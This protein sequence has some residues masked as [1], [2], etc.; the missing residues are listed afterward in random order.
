MP[1]STVYRK[2][3]T[4]RKPGHR[5]RCAQNDITAM[6][7]QAVWWLDRWHEVACPMEHPTITFQYTPR[8]RARPAQGK[9]A[10]STSA[11]RRTYQ[12]SESTRK[13]RAP[14]K[15]IRR[16]STKAIRLL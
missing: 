5:V 13:S 12:A 16:T 4:R 2:A 7:G 6:A 9:S 1:T 8:R 10:A 3:E 14:Q 11:G 15:L